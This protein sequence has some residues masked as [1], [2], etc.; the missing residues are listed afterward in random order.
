[1]ASLIHISEA[2]GSP[3]KALGEAAPERGSRALLVLLVAGCGLAPAFGGLYRL[4]LW[5]PIAL[6]LLALLFALI[7]ARPVALRRCAIAAVLGLAGL[8]LWSLLSISWA[9]SADRAAL[10]ASRWLLY[11]AFFSIL[12]LTIRSDRV[13]RLV[14]G[15]AGFAVAAFAAYLC[16]ALLL[17]GS[18]DLFLDA[19]LNYPLGYWNGQIGY[20]LIG[21][22]PLVAVAERSPRRAL[23]GAAL[24]AVVV[25]GGLAV[26]TQ[27]RAVVPATVVSALVVCVAVPGRKKRLWALALIALTVVVSASGLLDVYGQTRPGARQPD[28]GTIRSSVLILLLSAA[29]AGALWWGLRHVFEVSLGP[30]A[31]PRWL[32][33]ASA[34]GLVAV[35][36]ATGGLG[37]VVAGDPISAVDDQIEAFKRLDVRASQAATSRFASAGGNRY[38]YWRIALRQFEEEPLRGLGAGNYNQTYYLERRTAEDIRQPHSIELQTLAELGLVGLMALALFVGAVLAGFVRRS[39]RARFDPGEAMIAVGAGGAFL[40]WLVHTSVD[41]LHLIPGVTGIALCAAA[42]LVAPWTPHRQAEGV[43]SMLRL[44]TIG[45]CG[46][47]VLVGATLV[48]RAT[49]ADK[50]R[51]DS[52]ESVDEDPGRALEQAGDSLALNDESLPAYYAKATALARMDNYDGARATLLEAT[53]RE[54]HNFVPWGLLGDLALRRGDLVQARSDYGRASELNPRNAG[55]SSLAKNPRAGLPQ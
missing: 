23:A 35:L 5:G 30:R 45:V 8:W 48:G 38:D 7:V 26:L 11:L 55:L 40:F 52:Q 10:E 51:S 15:L 24:S 13:A 19:R 20:L 36:V 4:S 9:E 32:S 50:Y 17:P 43:S 53:R 54:P 14:V 46:L 34:G 25:L 22:W 2:A 42:V 44:A 3:G 12:V 21:L 33:A 6:A 39:S 16:V 27:T 29:A 49:L 31:R 41:W 1:M 28:E 37:L 47:V 18:S